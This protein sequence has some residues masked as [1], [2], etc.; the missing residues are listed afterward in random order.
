MKTEKGCHQSWQEYS[1]DRGNTLSSLRIGFSEQGHPDKQIRELPQLKTTSLLHSVPSTILSPEDMLVNK[2]CS[3]SSRCSLST[4]VDE[5][6]N[7]DLLH[8]A[9]YLSQG[10]G[11]KRCPRGAAEQNWEMSPSVPHST[12]GR[13]ASYKGQ[14]TRLWTLG[15]R[16]FSHRVWWCHHFRCVHFTRL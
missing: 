8:R 14:K 3:L 4:Q 6:V 7:R 10:W 1:M 9:E 2:I 12:E 5:Q 16:G 13:G 11:L 15:E